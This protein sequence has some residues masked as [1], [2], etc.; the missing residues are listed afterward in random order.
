[1]EITAATDLQGSLKGAMMVETTAL[2]NLDRVS[3]KEWL[4]AREWMVVPNDRC[5]CGRG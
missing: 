4:A 3:L 2:D 5:G 1:M